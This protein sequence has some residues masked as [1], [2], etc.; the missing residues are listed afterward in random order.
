MLPPHARMQHVQEGADGALRSAALC[1]KRADGT[2]AWALCA[3]DAACLVRTPWPVHEGRL[4][5]AAVALPRCMCQLLRCPRP[6]R[7]RGHALCCRGG[8]SS[9]RRPG[10]QLRVLCALQGAGRDDPFPPALMDA[11]L[12]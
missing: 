2:I 11:A 6:C 8:V 10:L 9:Q 4:V 5:L 7:S 3:E 1:L 12:Q